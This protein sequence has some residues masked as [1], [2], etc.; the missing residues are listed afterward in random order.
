MLFSE[1]GKNWNK[2][3]LLFPGLI[4]TLS[5]PF[6]L[7]IGIGATTG[8]GVALAMT[9]TVVVSVA[10]VTDTYVKV[11][12]GSDVKIVSMTVVGTGE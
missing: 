12:A 4:T 6:E 9:W 10:V 5:V 2:A 3:L 8:L 1:F 7:L 11:V